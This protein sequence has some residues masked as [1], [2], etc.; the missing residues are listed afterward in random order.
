M[1]FWITMDFSG[2]GVGFRNWPGELLGVVVVAG[3]TT[4]GGGG[5]TIEKKN[6]NTNENKI[7]EI[8]SCKKTEYIAIR[9]EAVV[10]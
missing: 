8:D 4:G 6:T 1:V 9:S 5:L 10:N 7:T 2:A 3:G